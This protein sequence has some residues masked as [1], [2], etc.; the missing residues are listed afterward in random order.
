MRFRNRSGELFFLL[1]ACLAQV[2]TVLAC[3]LWREVVFVP[4]RWKGPPLTQEYLVWYLDE[5]VP[6]STMRASCSPCTSPSLPC[7]GSCWWWGLCGC[8]SG[9]IGRAQDRRRSSSPWW[10]P[11]SWES[12]DSPSGCGSTASPTTSG[13]T[14]F[15]CASCPGRSSSFGGSPGS[16]PGAG[17]GPCLRCR[18]KIFA[19]TVPSSGQNTPL[20]TAQVPLR[21][22][23][24]VCLAW[25]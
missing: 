8:S 7:W 20:P 4:E 6:P 13:W 23:R 21:M 25:G 14:W 15:P 5:Y 11:A 19:Q 24:G 22:G 3:T 17:S 10:Q 2:V 9:F 1:L 16:A 12:W 18:P